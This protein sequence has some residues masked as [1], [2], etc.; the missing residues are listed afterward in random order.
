MAATVTA[1]SPVPPT[2][3]NPPGPPSATPESGAKQVYL[4]IAHTMGSPAGSSSVPPPASWI[5]GRITEAGEPVAAGLG[6]SAYGPHIELRRYE[7]GEWQKVATTATTDGGRFAFQNPPPLAPEQAYQVWWTV[8]PGQTGE[9][10]LE[11]WMSL[12]IETFQAGDVVDVGTFEVADTIELQLPGNHAR[13][14]FP[15]VF[16][17]QGREHGSDSYRWQISTQCW[18]GAGKAPG[19]AFRSWP[20]GRKSG[21]TLE[22]PP[23]GFDF[24]RSYCWSVFIDGGPNGSGWSHDFRAIAFCAE[25]D[26]CPGSFNVAETAPH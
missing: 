19:W 7:A 12:A 15:Q 9:R 6:S 11:R 26:G 3:T 14:S 18:D 24:D 16:R 20:L 13:G 22:T 4:P 17:W 10:W 23:P 1:T 2:A 8:A 21:F 5:V 25:R